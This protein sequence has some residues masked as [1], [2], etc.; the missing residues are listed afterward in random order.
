M[1]S[2][3]AR[4]WFQRVKKN[5]IDSDKAPLRH[6]YSL[7]QIA[8]LVQIMVRTSVS[9]RA[10]EQVLRIHR[11]LVGGPM[12]VPVH[13][14]ILNW[15]LKAGYYSLCR[16]KPMT[17]DW[18]IILDTS[19]QMGQEKVLAILGIR[20]GDI[21]FS[22]PLNHRDLSPLVL[23]VSRHWNSNGVHAEL[24]ALSCQLGGISY[25]VGDHGGEIKKGLELAGIRQV[26]D[27]SH[28]LALRV[29]RRYKDDERHK[30]FRAQVT[31]MRVRLG[32]SVAAHIVPPAQRNKSAY[33]NIRPLTNWATRALR[34]LESPEAG[35]P[36]H[37]RA[38]T[39]LSWLKNYKGLIW[40]LDELST[41]ITEVETVLKHQGLSQSTVKTANAIFNQMRIPDPGSFKTEFI[42]KLT[43]SIR[44]LSE[45]P[46]ILCTSDIIE[47]AFG[48]YKNFLSHN[49]MAGVTRLI[50]VIAAFCSSL[51]ED[52]VRE[53]MEK[54]TMSQVKQWTDINIGPT[55]YKKRNDI[56]R[57][58]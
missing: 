49:P 34:F 31:Q 54:T 25:A 22:R 43:D 17:G 33:Q 30:G 40:E 41:A 11:E 37:E 46:N 1:L 48:K 45:H 55:L 7:L 18:V 29:E 56:L 38:K 32:Q 42:A 12:L 44:L 2:Q 21:D 52:F 27:I 24:E 15:L 14:T 4:R 57:S 50:L 5:V 47:S 58:A 8:T 3:P 13:N 53:S 35:L 9:F 51:D 28:D 36:E 20:A 39:E 6:S 23:A 16:L 10:L 19:I 26:H